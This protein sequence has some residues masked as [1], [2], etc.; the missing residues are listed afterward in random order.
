MVRS[1]MYPPNGF[2]TEY[3]YF[4]IRTYFIYCHVNYQQ[5]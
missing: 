1:F 4:L 3:K 2:N 5:V